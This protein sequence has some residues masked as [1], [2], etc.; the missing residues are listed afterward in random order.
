[1]AEIPAKAVAVVKI[2]RACCS[3]P[4]CEDW[5]GGEYA[6]YAEANDLDRVPHLA[7]HREAARQDDDDG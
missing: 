2:F 4:G 1:M 6:T 5:R 3:L 7:A